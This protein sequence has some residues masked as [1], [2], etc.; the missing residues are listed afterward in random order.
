VGTSRR[1]SDLKEEALNLEQQIVTAKTQE[2]AKER[3][4][5]IKWSY[6]Y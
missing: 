4:R 2:S 6:H 5:G 1:R 3:E